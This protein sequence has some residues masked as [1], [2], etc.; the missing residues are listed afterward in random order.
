MIKAHK[1]KTMTLS[2]K[3]LGGVGQ[4][5]S[6]STLITHGATSIIIDCGILFPME[7]TFEIN[8]LIPDLSKVDEE[9]EAILI[10]HGHEDHIGAIAHY[11][12]AF[13]E[14]QI[15]AP[16]FARELIL[17]KLSH[18][19]FKHNIELLLPEFQVGDIK[20][21]SFHVN[22]SI[23]D[24]KGL[25]IS[26]EKV[27]M[28]FI[29][30]FKI[31]QYNPHERLFDFEVIKEHGKSNRNKICFLDSTN[32]LSKNLQ[33][34]SEGSV[35][36]DL[37]EIILNTTGNCYITT[38]SS[39]V[40]RIQTV[41]DIC[42]EH[43]I[44]VLPYGRSMKKYIE[45]A[46]RCTFLEPKGIIYDAEN[47]HVKRKKVILLTGCQGEMRGASSRVTSGTDKHFKLKSGDS[48]VFSSKAI[49]GNEKVLAMLYN[50]II[51]Q[52]ADVYLDPMYKIHVSGHP[53]KEDL[54]IIYDLFKPNHAFPIHGESLFLQ[55]HCDWITRE[56]LA[57]ESHFIQ[58]FDKVLA[59]DNQIEIIPG[60]ETPPLLIHGNMLEIERSKISERRKLAS[61]G[62]V[63]VSIFRSR[64]IDIELSFLGL[65]ESADDYKSE[66]AEHIFEI[67][68][69]TKKLSDHEIVEKSRVFVRQFFNQKLG[70]R[71]L[72]IVHMH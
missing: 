59:T 51:E 38:F 34:P 1:K 67:T 2:I 33:T 56:K 53:G 3:P 24:T 57:N 39:N 25:M 45:I 9:I 36:K 65:P 71:P 68:T 54:R 62:S 5:G 61:L 15:Y 27:S 21:E 52:G 47:K 14:A 48:F 70:Y 20:I 32:I 16:L 18:T 58:N 64:K 69:K 72:A 29:S 63:Y 66:L 8:Y 13:P 6:N 28:L 37:E 42:H 35:R 30:D 41:I 40:H 11:I 23:P 31:D 22:H 4:I 19:R 7:S 43:G 50:K 60:E 46:E 17:E 55:E 44:A 10:T 26:T 49:P 12:E